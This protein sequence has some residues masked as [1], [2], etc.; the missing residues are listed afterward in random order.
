MAL[1]ELRLF[2]INVAETRN[3]AGNFGGLP[4]SNVLKTVKWFFNYMEKSTLWK[5]DFIMD[6]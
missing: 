6:Q 1:S 2:W 5:S 4:N 3:Y